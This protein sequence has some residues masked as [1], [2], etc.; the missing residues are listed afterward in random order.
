MPYP[1]DEEF[2]L[3]IILVA[4]LR[5]RMPPLSDR[6]AQDVGMYMLKAMW[7]GAGE[8]IELVLEPVT[9]GD[10]KPSHLRLVT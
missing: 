3:L 9:Y 1:P 5:S 7:L 8:P 4:D 2:G 10:P 6:Q